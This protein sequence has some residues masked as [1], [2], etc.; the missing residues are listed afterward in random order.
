MSFIVS[1]PKYNIT[2]SFNY[3]EFT[4][5]FP[6]S[7]ITL[8]LQSGE[9][10]IPLDNPLVTPDILHVLSYIITNKDY[11]YISIPNAKKSLDYLGIDLPDMVFNPKYEEFRRDNPDL[12]LDN[13]SNNYGRELEYARDHKF[14]E[15]AQYLFSITNPEDTVDSDTKVFDNIIT[16][17]YIS[18]SDSKIAVMILLKRNIQLSHMDVE[19]IY[20]IIQNGDLSLFQTYINTLDRR[21]VPLTRE[22][23]V[24]Y[25]I[26]HIIYN[27][28]VHPEYFSNYIG[29]INVMGISFNENTKFPGVLRLYNLFYNIYMG[30]LEEVKTLKWVYIRLISRLGP[31]LLYT[32]LIRG[33]IDVY[34]YLFNVYLNRVI[35]YP[36]T[37]VEINAELSIWYN[38]FLQ[39]YLANPEFITPIGLQAVINTVKSFVPDLAQSYLN[40][41]KTTLSFY[42][43]L[44]SLI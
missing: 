28:I 34:N 17:D 25:V 1:L 22:S 12:T 18:E 43:E 44:V 21:G 15:L 30:N 39:A 7:L 4:S 2:V 36:I 20:H 31:S 3:D 24:Y 32:A 42:P 23:T 40:H 11:P 33:H 41:I 27:I 9:S 6:N 29:M 37:P 35:G 13:L 14:P 10:D 19:N 8:A 5:F 26:D 38:R 16:S